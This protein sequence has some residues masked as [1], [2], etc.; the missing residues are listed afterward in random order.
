[1]SEGRCGANISQIREAQPN[2]ELDW[3]DKFENTCTLDAGHEGAHVFGGEDGQQVH[4]DEA[5]KQVGV[6]QDEPAPERFTLSF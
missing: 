6:Y 1:M 5:T 3:L 2:S 4:L